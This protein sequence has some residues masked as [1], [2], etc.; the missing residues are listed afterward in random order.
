MRETKFRG[1]NNSGR[2][3]YGCLV[4]TESISPAIYY[5]IGTGSVKQLHWVYVKKESTGQFTGLTD[6]NGVDIYE[7]DVVEY[8]EF[9]RPCSR[10]GMR[11]E[12]KIPDIYLRM[13]GMKNI[14][15]IGNIHQNKKL[16]K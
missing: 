2:W 14:K 15:V 5:E 9:A 16:L 10:D 8:D 4:Y 7:G 13:N 3:V 6:K 11:I 12:V 1:I